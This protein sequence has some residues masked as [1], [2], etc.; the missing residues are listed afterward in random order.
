[1]TYG[2]PSSHK[3]A[4]VNHLHPN[5]SVY[6]LVTVLYSIL[7]DSI[8]DKYLLNSQELQLT[9]IFFNLVTSMF[10]LALIINQWSATF[11]H[12]F[13]WLLWNN[14]MT[15]SQMACWLTWWNTT[16]ISQKSWVPLLYRPKFFS[17]RLYFY[18]SLRS[19]SLT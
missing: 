8:N 15:S 19:V 3:P 9:I 18:Y 5:I 16:P 4:P 6:I 10:E 1:M 17:T 13:T 7:V 12:H 14:K 2:I 11:I